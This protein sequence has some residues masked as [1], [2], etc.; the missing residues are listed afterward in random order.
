MSALETLIADNVA[1]LRQGQRVLRRLDAE[2]YTR[3]HPTL[4]LSGVGSHLR[5]LLDFYARLLEGLEGGRID[6]DARD[7][8]PRLENDPRFAATH[9]QRLVQA[10]DA[11]RLREAP[12]TLAIKSDSEGS[13]ADETPWTVSSLERELQA[14][15]SHT[16][17][18]YALI[19]VGLR[20]E[21]IDPGPE[22]GV[23]PSTLRF[24][25]ATGVCAR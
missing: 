19:A 25:E 24:W 1:L 12:A 8:D 3:A 4:A 21:G 9:I 2:S 10:L 14:T 6:Y 7:R 16:V 15:L 5:H 11:L 22:F 20:L 23:A 17:H 18:H 13:G